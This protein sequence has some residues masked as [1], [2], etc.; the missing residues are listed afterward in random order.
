MV[1]TRGE[2]IPAKACVNNCTNK[3]AES[4]LKIPKDLF[5]DVKFYLAEENNEKV[6]NEREESFLHLHS[7]VKL[8]INAYLIFNAFFGGVI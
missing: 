1:T 4:G 6:R 5:K 2:I 8:F 7:R 3:M